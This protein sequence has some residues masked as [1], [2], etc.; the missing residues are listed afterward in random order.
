MIHKP[1]LTQRT[2]E[3]KAKTDAKHGR[4]NPETGTAHECAKPGHWHNA[5][6]SQTLTLAQR[7]D[8]PNKTQNL[9]NARTSQKSK[10]ERHMTQLT[11]GAKPNTDT[12][13]VPAKT[14]TT[15]AQVK[16]RNWHDA[17]P[18]Q[19]SKVKT[20]TTHGRPTNIIWN[21]GR[22]SQKVKTDRTNARFKPQNWGNERTSQK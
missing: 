12:T 3:P 15:Y 11:H 1:K 10:T 8:E 22:M 14:D 17:R 13:H 5:R 19:K 6:T 20:E 16:T 18:S 2:S 9:H 7:T 4:P 21:N